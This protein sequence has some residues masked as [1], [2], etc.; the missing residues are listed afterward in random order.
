MWKYEN[1][2]ITE[3][4]PELI[5]KLYRNIS[6]W[7]E[8]DKEII[9]VML[10]GPFEKG[11]TGYLALIGQEPLPFKLTEVKENEFFSNT[12]VLEQIGIQIDFNHR[13]EIHN[14]KTRVTHGV[15]ILGPNSEKMG[16]KIGPL[17]TQG[18]PNSMSNLDMLARGRIL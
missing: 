9:D 10:D 2:I 4:K 14:S 1:S 16:N 6:E 15:V 12:T 5:W 17:I 13:I 11:G 3:A 8:W 7:K 18:I